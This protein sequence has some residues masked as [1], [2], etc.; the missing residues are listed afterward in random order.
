MPRTPLA[1]RQQ[2]LT[3][4]RQSGLTQAAFAKQ[5][6]LNAN[7]LHGW[8]R[9]DRLLPRPAFLEVHPVPALDPHSCQ[10]HLGPH[11]SLQLSTLP[12]PTWL[13]ALVRGLAC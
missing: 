12:D 1:Q 8:L 10:L 7:T 5:H 9:K 13:A 3:H 2:I 11:L 4:F 6:A